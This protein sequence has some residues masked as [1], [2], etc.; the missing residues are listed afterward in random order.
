MVEHQLFWMIILWMS[1]I[2]ILEDSRY[3]PRNTEVILDI[4]MDETEDFFEDEKTKEEVIAIIQS[5]V[6]LYL[7]EIK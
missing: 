6:Q 4:I 3:L 5:R 7:D 1:C 2:I